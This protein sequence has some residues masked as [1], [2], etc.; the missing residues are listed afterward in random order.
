MRISDWSSDVCSSDLLHGESE[1]VD[2]LAVLGAEH[3]SADDGVVGLVD[4][5][6]RGCRWFSDSVVRVPAAR[7]RV[8]DLHFDAARSRFVFEKA[9]AGPFR[10][11]DDCRGHTAVESGRDA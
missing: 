8:A 5:D 11:G 9:D 4:E 2:Q 1:E 7:I 10:D 6:L 3:V